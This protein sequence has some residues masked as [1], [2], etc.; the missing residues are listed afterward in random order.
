M[1]DTQLKSLG[2]GLCDQMSTQVG[3]SP[4]CAM[5]CILN[6]S[7]TVMLEAWLKPVVLMGGGR[8]TGQ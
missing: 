2:S 8:T 6:A 5:V 3:G 1:D 7:L 4:T